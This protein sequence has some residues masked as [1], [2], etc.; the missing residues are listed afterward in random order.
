VIRLYAIIR[1]DG[2]IKKGSAG[3]VALY[4]QYARACFWAKDE[5]DSVVEVDIDLSKPP[6]YIRGKVL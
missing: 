1:A 3:Q 6:L 4:T 2:S 5:G